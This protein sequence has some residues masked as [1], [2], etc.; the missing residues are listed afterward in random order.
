MSRNRKRAVDHGQLQEF[1]RRTRLCPRVE[2][3][4]R[5]GMACVEEGGPALTS[6]TY[7]ETGW[8]NWGDFLGTGNK[9]GRPMNNVD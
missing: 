4:G 3:V 9:S 7:K 8:T 1:R 5:E 2:A 6:P